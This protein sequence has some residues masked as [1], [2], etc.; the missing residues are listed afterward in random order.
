M[1]DL[2]ED[3]FYVQ[4]L[5][6]T[7]PGLPRPRTDD[8]RY[9]VPWNAL[10]NRLGKLIAPRLKVTRRGAHCQVCGKRLDLSRRALMFLRPEVEE[11]VVGVA[12]GEALRAADEGLL[13]PGCAALALKYCPV[14][15]KDRERGVLFLYLVPTAMGVVIPFEKCSE[16]PVAILDWF[17]PPE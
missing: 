6:T 12:E 8:G 2:P 16:L 7:E 5:P 14:L 3:S 11:T 4:D 10:A 15:R 13:H 1:K 9:P 17:V